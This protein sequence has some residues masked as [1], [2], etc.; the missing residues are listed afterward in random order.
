MSSYKHKKKYGQNFLDSKELLEKIKNVVNLNKDTTVLEIGPG[1][2]YLT[3]MIL[4]NAKFLTSYE[5]DSDLISNLEKKFKKYDN[6]KLINEDFML[7]DI[8]GENLKVVANIPYYI[9]TPIVEKLIE[10]K[11]KIDE[12][13]IMVQKEVAIRL[14]TE[15][16]GSDV[17]TLTHYIRYYTIPEYLFTVEKEYFNPIPKVDS[18]FIKLKIRKDRKY[19]NMIDE[20]IYFSFI[21][22]AFSQKR[23]TLINNLK[24]A[25]FDKEELEKNLVNDKIRAE[26]LSIEQFID[27]IKGLK[28]DRL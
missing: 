22:K 21:K 17:S 24:K 9:T 25:G 3:S 19:E 18:A 27:L 14:C 26:E 8:V 12:I 28:Y 6:F 4:E 16:S 23:K 15:F 13:Y 11:E 5:I 1:E 10:N 7:S 2:G 20:K